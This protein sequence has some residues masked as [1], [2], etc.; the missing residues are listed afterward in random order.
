MTWGPEDASEKAREIRILGRSSGW[1]APFVADQH[2]EDEKIE[3]YWNV[4]PDPIWR[5]SE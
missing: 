5:V 4:E 1:E 2:E 3:R